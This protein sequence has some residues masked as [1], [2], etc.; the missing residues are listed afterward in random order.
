VQNADTPLL[1]IF[2]IFIGMK[3]IPTLCIVLQAIFSLTAQNGLP[4]NAGARGAAMGGVSVAFQDI[5]SA[6]SN[7]AGLATLPTWGAAS[8]GEQRF[9]IP[10]IRSVA[11]AAA[12]PTGAGAFGVNL[13]YFGLEEYNEQR[14]GF[15]YARQ[16]FQN[17]YLGVEIDL[18]NTRIPDFGSQLRATGGAGLQVQMADPLWVGVHLFNPFCIQRDNG[19]YYPTLMK[20]GF[21]YHASQ[22]LLLSGEAEKDIDFPLRW[23]GGIEYLYIEALSFRAGF[24]TQPIQGSFGAG[25]AWKSG[26]RLDFAF[27]WH[28]ILG[29]TPAFSAIFQA[30]TK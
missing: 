12:F 2:H 27:Q 18:L 5:N 26:L 7:P 30:P 29:V 16:V 25:L 9:L 19:E 3:A 14:V 17:T 22:K 11:A 21:S 28:Q 20:A 13:Q 24:S 15:L 23:K 10:D 4:P 1:R 6:F 8:L